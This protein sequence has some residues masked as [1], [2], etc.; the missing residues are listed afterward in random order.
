MAAEHAS[1]NKTQ[2]ESATGR[3]A[4][5]TDLYMA[6][7]LGLGGAR[8]FLSAMRSSPGRSGASLFPAAARANRGI[9][10][11]ATGSARSLAQIY[12][13]FTSKLEQGAEGAGGMIPAVATQLDA[14]RLGAW[15]AD[16]IPGSGDASTS[17][18]VVWAQSTLERLT[19]AAGATNRTQ[20]AANLLRPTPD[21]ARLAYMMLASM[22]A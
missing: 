3:A 7:F 18:A 17:D 15:G 21:N 1:D 11:D 6:H 20:S 5:G 14:T 16:V 8:S 13:R 12:T 10:Y 9:F 22:G 2:L 19:G 4:T